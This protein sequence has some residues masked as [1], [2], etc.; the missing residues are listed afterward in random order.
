M[1]RGAARSVGQGVVLAGAASRTEDDLGQG[2][3]TVRREHR[4]GLRGSGLDLGGAVEVDQRRHRHQTG[5]HRQARCLGGQRDLEGQV[6]A[7]RVAHDHDLRRRHPG[8]EH[9]PVG[10]EAVGDRG[11]DRVVRE[12]PV[13]D[14][15]DRRTGA[16][17]DLRHQV[18]VQETPADDEGAAVQVDD[19]PVLGLRGAQDLGPAVRQVDPL[20]RRTGDRLE[21]QAGVVDEEVGPRHQ[22]HPGPDRDERADRVAQRAREHGGPGAAATEVRRHRA[23]L[24]R[25]LVLRRDGRRPGHQREPGSCVRR[26]HRRVS[27]LRSAP[28]P[29]GETPLPKGRFPR[30]LTN[31]ARTRRS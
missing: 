3:E 16:V 22:G 17:R 26:A 13:V 12:L 27:C 10:V 4:A 5:R 2:V 8:V 14:R 28:Q 24:D 21:Q 7:G 18:P 20:V 19:D 31:S 25:A 15:D 23:P 9:V 30:R 11:A 29:I 6:A 1:Q